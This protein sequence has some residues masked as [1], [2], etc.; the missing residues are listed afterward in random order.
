M[1]PIHFYFI[2]MI[3]LHLWLNC[4]IT[5]WYGHYINSIREKAKA[6]AKAQANH[7]E[8]KYPQNPKTDY[9]II[10]YDKQFQPQ[11]A[12]DLLFN[13]FYLFLFCFLVRPLTVSP[14]L[15]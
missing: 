15:V 5:I 13:R 12:L 3:A 14:S 7:I 1:F 6:K 11:R 8:M 10:V 4:E 9:Y 2:Q